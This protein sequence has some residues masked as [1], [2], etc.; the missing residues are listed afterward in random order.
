ML[1]AQQKKTIRIEETHSSLREATI[2]P[3]GIEILAAQLYDPHTSLFSGDTFDALAIRREIIGGLGSLLTSHGVTVRDLRGAFA[4]SLQPSSLS[5]QA[6]LEKVAATYEGI[7]IDQAEQLLYQEAFHYNSMPHAIAANH[8]LTLEHA[9]PLGNIIYQCDNSGVIHGYNFKGTMKY[10]IRQPEPDVVAQ[11]LMQMGYGTLFPIEG[12]F[13]Y[14]DVAFIDGAV[15][16]GQDV[17]YGMRTSAAA[18]HQIAGMIDAPVYALVLTG[19]HVPAEQEQFAHIQSRMHLDLIA[20]EPIEGVLYGCPEICCDIVVEGRNE[21][22]GTQQEGFYEH[23]RGMQHREIP[24]EEQQ[25]LALNMSGTKR[26]TVVVPSL[27]N[28]T[29]VQYL[30]DD[31]LTVVSPEFEHLP[32]L[33]GGAHCAIGE[34]ARFD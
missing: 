30:H 17:G 31:G 13:E 12:V 2:F 4:A 5:P 9:L 25:A 18:I 34:L 11:G 32:K 26:G 3:P 14:A 20:K 15:Y 27:E 19:E 21:Y 7:P 28:E 29:T 23:F 8:A 1:P 6:F 24:I 33:L 16:I 22:A 10:P